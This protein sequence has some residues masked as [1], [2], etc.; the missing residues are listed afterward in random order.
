MECSRGTGL[1]KWIPEATGSFDC[2]SGKF[3]NEVVAFDAWGKLTNYGSSF[4]FILNNSG[5]ADAALSCKESREVNG[6]ISA[7][8]K[9]T[10]ADTFGLEVFERSRNVQETLASRAD[11]RHRGTSKLGKIGY[12][13]LSIIGGAGFVSTVFP[14]RDIH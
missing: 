10:N 8:S 6:A 4:G 14:T 9:C 5:T 7:I 11:Y 13:H 2:A 1:A 3:V 12:N